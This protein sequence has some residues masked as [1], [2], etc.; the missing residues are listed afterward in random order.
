MLVIL[1]LNNPD[2]GAVTHSIV[3]KALLE[4][5]TEINKLGEVE[6]EKARREI[7]DA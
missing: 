4:Y 6:A 5:L 7:F 3:H 1:S 2:K